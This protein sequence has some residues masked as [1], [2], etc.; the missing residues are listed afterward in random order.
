M[1]VPL[2]SVS[3]IL[4]RME[5]FCLLLLLL[6][7]IT[8]ALCRYHFIL[9]WAPL[10][11]QKLCSSQSQTKVFCSSPQVAMK[12][13]LLPCAS[14]PHGARAGW[15]PYPEGQAYWEWS[16]VSTSSVLGT[17]VPPRWKLAN[18]LPLLSPLLGT[19]KLSLKE[20]KGLN[21]RAPGW[22]HSGLRFSEQR[23]LSSLDESGWGVRGCESATERPSLN[24]SCI[25]LN[26]GLCL[27]CHSSGHEKTRACFLKDL[28]VEKKF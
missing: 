7:F 22:P 9:T 15:L 16:L 18:F 10:S 5:D 4:Q 26:T 17:R 20:P 1:S 27:S 3:T 25:T 12:R 8:G 6:L 13:L 28:F 11:G 14:R 21:V 24:Y 19:Y 23:A 2:F